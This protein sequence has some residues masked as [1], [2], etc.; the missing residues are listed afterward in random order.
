MPLPWKPERG[1]AQS[2]NRVREQARIQVEGREAGSVLHE[3]LA[4]TPGF[5]LAS[6][7]EPSPGDIFFDL[8]GDPFAGEGGLEYLC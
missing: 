1:V 7:P 3:L 6:L 5:G 4:V 2:Y 8:E